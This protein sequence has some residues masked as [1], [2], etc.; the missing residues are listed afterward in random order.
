MDDMDSRHPETELI[1]YLKDELE[2]ASRET[3]A[4]HLDDCAA[5]RDTLTAFRTLLDGVAA[6]AAPPVQW[7]RYRAELRVRLANMGGL[8]TGPPSPPDAR[9][10]PAKPWRSSRYSDRLRGAW[11][12]R[13]WPVAVSA[14][15]AAAVVVLVILAPSAWRE[16]RRARTAEGLNGFEEVVLG[17]R[18][19]LLRQ[20]PIVER[21]EL[22]EDLDVIRQLDAERR[23][24]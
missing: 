3:V 8:A 7:A 23:E 19:D 5:C 1:A 12:L 6:T 4:R 18:L 11:W 21:L 24:G 10:A 17:T 20:Y 13:R 2:H 9:R 22:L 15:L 14:G 16:E